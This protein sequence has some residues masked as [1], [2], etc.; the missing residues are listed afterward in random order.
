M[1]SSKTTNGHQVST[2]ADLLAL[3][4]PYEDVPVPEFGNEVHVRLNAVTGLKRAE[5]AEQNEKNENAGE[6][7]RFVHELIAAS[8]GGDATAES[9]AGLPAAVIDRLSKVAM[10]MAGIGAGAVDEAEADL[11]AAPSAANG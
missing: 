4:L 5:L 3:P 6:R 10:K 9:V 8:L 1:T 7:L 2:L 11:P